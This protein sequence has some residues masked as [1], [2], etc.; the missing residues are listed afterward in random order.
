MCDVIV[1]GAGPAG[2]AAARA[3]A[4]RGLST[5]CIEEH[6]TI[7]YPV[8]CAGLL[9]LA[10]FEECRV[11]RR[12]ILN[13]VTGA[14][15]ISSRGSELCFDAR[16]PKAVIVDRGALDFEMADNAAESGADFLTKSAVCGIAGTRLLT[17][18]IRGK[19][20]FPFRLLIAADGP[21]S[22]IAR[23][24]NMQRASTYLAGIQADIPYAM[25][26]NLAE[27]YPDAAPDFFGYAIPIADTRA[28]IGLCTGCWAKERFAAFARQ[29][30]DRNLHL[31]TGTVPL[32]VMPRTYGHRTLFCGDAAGFA[33]PT[34]GGG[35]YTGVRSARHAAAVAIACCEKNR[36]DDAALSSYEMLWKKD[37]GAMLEAGYRFFR[38]REQLAPG[39]IDRIIRALN[40]PEI[41]DTIIRYGDMDQPGIL[42]RKLVLK[43]AVIRSLG[44]LVRS[45]FLSLFR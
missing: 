21:K 4:E 29:F 34:S 32:G 19:Q 42:I 11:S 14:R 16:Q 15:V 22:T 28:R 24:L 44:P 45:G 39:D 10:A 23:L 7:G 33:K 25:D 13:T 38:L 9:S 43:P 40:D 1:A 26:C 20:E 5:L 17:R 2:C 12:S 36:F 35:V 30:T 6:G 31:V 8:Q 3:C 41:I 37:M 18:G 27:I